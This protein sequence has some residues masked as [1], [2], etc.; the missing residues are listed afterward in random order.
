MESSPVPAPAH[1][2]ATDV[3][4]RGVTWLLRELSRRE[5]RGRPGLARTEATRHPPH[6]GP[7]TMCC[8]C[9]GG[10]TSFCRDGY[11]ESHSCFEACQTAN[12]HGGISAVFRA[13]LGI[14][15]TCAAAPAIRC[16]ATSR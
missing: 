3:S 11:H 6:E 10:S 14:H 12:P 13:H 16:V 5:S 15:Y 2:L 9:E 8:V 4:R 1:T 7:A